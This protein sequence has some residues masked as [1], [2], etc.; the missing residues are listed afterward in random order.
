VAQRSSLLIFAV[1]VLVLPGS[2][3]FSQ[4]PPY[5]WIENHPHSQ[6]LARRIQL[7]SG[8]RRVSLPADSFG[9]W[10][11]HLPLKRGTPPV[12]L[13]DGTRKSNQDAHAAVLDIDVGPG[14]RQQCA[15]AVIRLRAEYLY[16]SGFLN[17]IVFNFTSGDP[18]RFRD[19]A[20]GFRPRVS[21]NRVSWVRSAGI[22][23]GYRNFRN[24]LNTV[25]MYAGSHSL[26]NELKPVGDI[27]K[28]RVGDVF[29]QGGFPGHAVLVVDMAVHESS[30]R[31]I[32]LLIQS[33][34]PAQDIHVFK[35]PRNPDFSPWY[36]LHFSGILETPEW[37]F[38]RVDLRRF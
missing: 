10:L 1:V 17:D 9:Y 27:E 29:I 33:Y 4:K 28:M 8:Y 20:R 34:M 7:P 25:F 36:D 24:Y 3:V 22:D 6:S 14:N 38:R 32:F 37:N 19:W 23:H 13:H 15:D 31:K 30:G 12:F 18:A 35:N 21:G 26:Q 2:S 11:R 16:F 5:A